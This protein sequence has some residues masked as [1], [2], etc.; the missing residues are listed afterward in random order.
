MHIFITS[1][2]SRG[3]EMLHYAHGLENAGHVVTSRW[4]REAQDAKPSRKASDEDRERAAIRNFEDLTKSDAVVSFSE[5]LTKDGR[6]VTPKGGAVPS[7]GA[8]HTDFGIGIALNK[9]MFVVGEREHIHHHLPNVEVYPD[10][11]TFLNAIEGDT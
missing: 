3:P 9:R 10:F 11:G 7:R 2:F 5:R 4:I 6:P 8:R 1:R